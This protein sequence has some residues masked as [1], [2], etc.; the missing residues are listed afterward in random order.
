MTRHPDIEIYIKNTSV[1]KITAW[2]SQR[3][4]KIHAL[5]NKGL[6]HQF[7]GEYQQHT[8]EI[9]I[10]ERALGKAWLSVWF[11][12]DQTPWEVDLD[13]AREASIEL[14]AQVRCIA[15]GWQEGDD[16]DEWWKVEQG[17]EEKIQWATD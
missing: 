1:E 11:Q 4:D 12:T 10:H 14:K 7:T 9:V 17:Q 5:G 16:P 15:S 2:L 6:L 8:F 3:L 13:C